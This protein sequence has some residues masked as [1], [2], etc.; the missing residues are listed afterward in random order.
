MDNIKSIKI[1]ANLHRAIKAKAAEEGKNIS[2]W[3]E[4]AIKD[5]LGPTKRE[6]IL[7]EMLV[8]P[9]LRM[10]YDEIGTKGALPSVVVERVTEKNPRDRS[11]EIR[12][13][14]ERLKQLGAIKEV[15]LLN[16]PVKGDQVVY[17]RDIEI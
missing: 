13:A 12:N 17:F 6:R 16:P 11:G 14:I 10:V 3:L 5:K 15:P 1:N 4:I 8:N 7:A 2:E 9:L